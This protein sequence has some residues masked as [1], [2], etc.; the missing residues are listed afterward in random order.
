MACFGAALL[1]AGRSRSVHAAEIAWHAPVEC[2]DSRQSVEEAERLLGRPLASVNR[3]DFEVVIGRNADQSWSLQL[4]TVDRQTQERRERLLTAASC[5]EAISAAAVA[6]AMVV[7]ASEPEPTPEP[8]PDQDARVVAPPAAPRRSQPAVVARP[9]PPAKRWSGALSLG[10]A[11]DA[12]SLPGVAPGAELGAS[13]RY[14]ALQLALL[15]AFY[16]GAERHVEGDKGAELQLAIAGLLVCGR[17]SLGA[18]KALVCGGSEAGWLTGTGIGLKDPRSDGFFWW[19]PRAEFGAS[20]PIGGPL[21]LLG[22]AGVALPRV[23]REFVVD[24]DLF[25]HRP[26]ALAARLLLGLELSLE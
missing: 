25:V 18:T 13:L 3:V 10:L 1:V 11:G 9:T 14:G 16:A 20:W 19:A 7:N 24:G 5:N 8:T 26:S 12:G 4:T 2:S 6:M 23:R 21:S 15:G 22:R 17:W